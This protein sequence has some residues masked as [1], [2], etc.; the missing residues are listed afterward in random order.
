MS[1]SDIVRVL[2]RE[3]SCTAREITDATHLSDGTV[4][5]NLRR[6]VKGGDVCYEIREN[7]CVKV[8]VYALVDPDSYREEV[9]V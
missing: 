2:L 6:M 8:R 1:Q 4:R 3:G 9:V 7:G 5:T